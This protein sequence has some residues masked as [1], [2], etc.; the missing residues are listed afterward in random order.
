L[1]LKNKGGTIMP[2]KAKYIKDLPLKRVLDGS[3]SLL[4]QDLNGTQQAPLGTIVDE[5]KQNS[6]E[7]I[8]EIESELN[9]TNAQ[10]SIMKTQHVNIRE[11]GAKGD[12]IADDTKAIIDAISHSE[13]SSIKNV[14][15]PSGVY[16]ITKKISVPWGVNLIGI[17]NQSTLQVEFDSDYAVE[18]NGR[19]LI[20]NIR[21]F[22]PDNDTNTTS[23]P[24]VFPA[25][26][27]ADNLGYSTLRNVCVGNA[28][29][30]IYFKTI[31]GGCL[32]E[33]VYG[34]PLYRGI[35]VEHCIDVTPVSRVHFNPNFF[36]VPNLEL[37]KFVFENAIALRI[38]RLDFCNVDKA[39]AWGYK[40]LFQL[41]ASPKGGSANNIKFTNWI[42]DACQFL[43][44]FNNHDG[45]ISFTNGTGTFYNPYE[46]EE[47]ENGIAPTVLSNYAVHVKGGGD[48]IWGGNLVSFVNNRIYRCERHFMRTTNPIIFIGN[49]VTRYA[50]AYSESD[51]AVV[52]CIQLATGASNSII[53]NNL[54]DGKSL[55]KNRC[56]SIVDVSNI[57]VVGN[58]FLGYK[59]VDVYK[60][61][62]GNNINLNSTAKSINSPSRFQIAEKDV[63]SKFDGWDKNKLY[64][65]IYSNGGVENTHFSNGV[66]LG[67]NLEV[68][69]GS[70][71]PTTSSQDLGDGSHR[72][73]N[74]IFNGV[75][76]TGLGSSSNRPTNVEPASFWFDASLGKPIWWTGSIWVDASGNQV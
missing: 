2:V 6:Q 66:R 31:N 76:R 32:I 19:H 53:A 52:D 36:G 73:R 11:F 30:G 50:N 8:R 48:G 68:L 35:E 22:Y 60:N 26:I 71:I 49:E 9:Q 65:N 55:A 24:K 43:C 14:F 1:K 7:K 15:I 75:V 37:R 40:S 20:E 28:Y 39:F 4:V 41:D 69:A 23:T 59:A 64:L 47:Q 56:V 62:E 70:I 61:T 18:L 57:T 25:S 51:S 17:Y 67:G 10:L 5:I 16:K 13:N 38:G 46:K 54:I 34:Y 3:E 63:L 42:A 72:W 12:G 45:G 33:N 58:V 21:F 44:I 74:G 27:F 29:V